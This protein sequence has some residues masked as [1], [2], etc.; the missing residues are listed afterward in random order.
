M[1]VGSDESVKVW[2]NGVLVHNNPADRG[3]R[4]Y[5]DTFSVT[6]KQGRNILLVAV[7]NGRWHWSGF[8][9]FEN[10]AVYSLASTSVVH[11]GAAER[12]PLY[13]IDASTGTLQLLIGEEVENLLPGVQ[14][15]ISLA[16][17]NN[18]MYWTEDAGG[19]HRG[20]Q[21]RESGG[22]KRE[23]PHLPAKCTDEH[24]R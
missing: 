17:A 7:Y 24:C 11:I 4:D 3:A 22:F 6:L 2:L 15:A 13:W 21:T 8:F 5:Q 12:P 23:R 10:D 1:Y 20:Y 19:K 18:K 9:G 14:N 16:V